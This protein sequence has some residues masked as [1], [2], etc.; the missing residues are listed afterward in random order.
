M[1]KK[2]I[3]KHILDLCMSV[4]LLFLMAYQVTGEKAHEWLGIAMFVLIV[5]HNLLNVKWYASIF[6]GEYN[7]LRVSRLLVNILLLTA[8][9]ATMVSGILLNSFVYPLNIVGTMATAR[10]LHLAG[11]YW[12]F[13]LMSIHL[14]LHW[15]VFIGFADI[16]LKQKTVRNVIFLLLRLLAVVIAVYGGYLF[17][18]ADIFDY[19]T[20][21]THFAFLDYDR[22]PVLVISDQ[23]VMMFFWVFMSY[24][25]TRIVQYFSGLQNRKKAQ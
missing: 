21:Q 9:L 17:L 7:V 6:R 15:G 25:F 24:Y 19:M 22:L 5:A 14:G 16:K 10:V 11:A 8:M 20:F 2:N 18:N 3:S 4:N 12:S 23:I 13:V 1:K